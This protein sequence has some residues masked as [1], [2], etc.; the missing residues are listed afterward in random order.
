MPDAV[1]YLG[2]CVEVTR[3]MAAESV[4]A[5]VCDPPAGIA[6]MNRA[7]DHD[8]GGR[9]QWIAWLAEVMAECLRVAKPG[10]HA[11]VWALPRTSHWTAT[12]IED[13]GW[14]IRD[15]ITHHFGSGFPKS[16]DVSKAIDK[17]RN[18]DVRPVCR[19]LRAAM[20]RAG[21]SAQGIAALFGFHSRMVDH[22]AARDTDSQPTVPTTEQWAALKDVLAFDDSMDAEV[23]RLN[24]RKGEVGDAYRDA[25]VVGEH[26][27]DA[28]GLAGERFAVSDRLVRA[29]ATEA[30]RQWSGFGTALKPASEHWILARK[31]PDGTVAANVQ[32]HGTGAINIDACRV[33]TQDDL[34]SRCSRRDAEGNCTGH[35]DAGQAQS[36]ETR[37]APLRGDGRD[38]EPSADRRYAD[39]GGT[40]FAATPGPRG[41]D[42]CGR[43][44]AN[45]VLTHSVD[46]VRAGTRRVAGSHSVGEAP[47]AYTHDRVVPVTSGARRP[48]DFVGLD[49]LEAVEAWTCA[50]DCPVAELDRQSGE[51][52][53]G[54]ALAGTEPSRTGDLGIYGAYGA[55]SPRPAMADT[56]GA[57]RFFPQ[58]AWDESDAEANWFPFRYVAKA[59]RRE[60]ER[61]LAEAGIAP[62]LA[63]DV[64]D[65]EPDSAGNR[66]PR[67][68]AGR[69]AGAE[70]AKCSACGVNL[71]GGR[72]VTPCA[73]SE[74][75]GHS[76]VA[77]SR[78][79]GIRNHHPTVKPVALMRWLVR[80]VTPPRTPSGDRGIVLDPFLGSGTTGVAATLEGFDFVG[81]E[82][83]PEY[84]A[85]AKARAEHHGAIV[86]VVASPG[87]EGGAP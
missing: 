69:G 30:A 85:I 59:P 35:G 51:R 14:E 25:E 74:D 54:G 76:P 19:F 36:G 86:T 7:W 22:W 71:G 52:Q 67:A 47:K 49:G 16:L 75:G 77:V 81:I 39:A 66:T 18:D 83:E 42:V 46:C 62:R 31:P 79:P 12:A 82:R 55:R 56:G 34:S 80:L 37:H 63:P 70:R 68:G 15:V 64:T 8:R 84:H 50:P 58:F 60:R 73:A 32:A 4:D 2:D 45:L 44:P 53:G 10:A 6:F 33:A 43:W 23:E 9:R 72:A 21:M 1:L 78:G 24:A 57:S 29:A 61:G 28:P 11:L 13:A 41:G 38:G 17:A 3:G 27:G 87:A 26:T 40:D 48:H 5:V 65:R 20:D